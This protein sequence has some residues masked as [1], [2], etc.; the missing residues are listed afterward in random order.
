MRGR[1]RDAKDMV[2]HLGNLS[3][4]SNHEKSTFLLANFVTTE[5]NKL[6]MTTD[7]PFVCG[8]RGAGKSAVSYWMAQRGGFRSTIYLREEYYRD[9][10]DQLL[11]SIISL[12]GGFTLPVAN[13]I[14]IYDR[15]WSYLI[16]ICVTSS[17]YKIA[18]EDGTPAET[19]EPIKSFLEDGNGAIQ[20]PPRIAYDRIMNELLACTAGPNALV[21]FSGRLQGLIE[22]G[23]PQRIWSLTTD[24]MRDNSLFI[25]IDTRER[26]AP[27]EIQLAP[28]RGLCR[29]VSRFHEKEVGGPNV[30]L[31]C[32][33]P[34]ELTP[35]VFLE[36]EM[37]YRAQTVTLDWHYS[38]LI[39]FIALRYSGFLLKKGQDIPHALELG[40]RVRETVSR[41]KQEK[42]LGNKVY[43]DH[44]WQLFAVPEITNLL[45]WNEDSAAYLIRHT[46]KRP[47]EIL[48]SMNYIVQCMLEDSALPILSES[49]IVTG[50]HSTG[51]LMQLMTDS[52]AV[53][54][55]PPGLRWATNLS[56][57]IRHVMENE[58]KIIHY[59]ALRECMKRVYSRYEGSRKD[60]LL[61][62]MIRVLLRSGLMGVVNLPAH[63]W[64]EPE[65]NQKRY[66][67][68]DFEYN[69]PGFLE[70]NEKSVCAM[71]PLL[72][73]S[74]RT[75]PSNY[76][77]GV[78][79]HSPE[80]DDIAIID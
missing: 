19:L 78:V 66:Y 5:K 10:H 79:Y 38:E 3:S 37:K 58:P 69:V 23:T 64:E 51:N 76:P 59:P 54:G 48:S 80:E 24:I 29:A 46:Q 28:Y 21:V 33:L 12:N 13:V 31:K 56:D 18:Q 35:Y 57:L 50:L 30:H 67:M 74:I 65:G 49:A 6:A 71:H 40:H 16:N 15:I 4:D 68:T 7:Y 26:Y 77:A 73:D 55:I 22:E 70:P 44:V 72:S 34:A 1:M 52:L 11:T 9:L 53:F 2:P 20:E 60:L 42:L 27:D 25:S 17:A 43:R 47:R 63:E 41:I 8:R 61:E 39:E 14:N 75:V 32:F 62:D 45:G 36:K